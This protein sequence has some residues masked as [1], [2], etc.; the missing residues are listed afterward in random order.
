MEVFTHIHTE[1]LLAT[2]YLEASLAH[3]DFAQFLF[4]GYFANLIFFL[5]KVR[6]CEILFALKCLET[7][8]AKCIALFM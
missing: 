4:P 1:R 2:L 3:R 8:A 5:S 6:R 7:L